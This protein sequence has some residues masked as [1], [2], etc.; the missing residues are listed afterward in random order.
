MDDKCEAQS[1]HCGSSDVTVSVPP[2][3][4]VVFMIHHRPVLVEPT[5]G[6]IVKLYETFIALLTS[7]L[8]HLE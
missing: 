7:P 8:V 4:L 6:L 5:L 1:D 3:T 2:Q